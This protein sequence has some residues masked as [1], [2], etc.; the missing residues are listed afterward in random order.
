M[1]EITA[2]KTEVGHHPESATI[3]RLELE[4]SCSPPQ[5]VFW[6]LLQA[7][8]PSK[9]TG[10]DHVSATC[11]SRPIFATNKQPTSCHSF[12]FK[13][14]S[15]LGSRLVSLDNILSQN[16]NTFKSCDRELWV[17][18]VTSELHRESKKQ[19]TK[20]LAITSLTI[21]R[22]S[23]FYQYRFGSKFATDSC[24]NIPPRFKYV[25]TLPCEIWMQKNGIILKYVLQLMMNH[26]VV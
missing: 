3:R 4:E 20:L 5:L 17:T 16:R 24:L 25:V 10:T 18:T 12:S 19:D 2:N 22:F 26:K 13:F 1:G 23:K 9:T 8:I 7:Y 15:A 6:Y 11:N 21:I 14:Q